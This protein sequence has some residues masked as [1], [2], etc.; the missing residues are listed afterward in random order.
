ML[1]PWDLRYGTEFDLLDPKVMDALIQLIRDGRIGWLWLAPPCTSHS[2]AQNG[3][4]GGQ[5]RSPAF[6]EGVPPVHPLAEWGNDLWN[7]SID[8]FQEALDASVFAAIEHP[9]TSYAW[10]CK[11]SQ[12]ALERE[13]VARL[14][15]DMCMFPD[16][17][18]QR[19]LKP[20]A[21]MTNMPWL[22]ML[23][24][25]CSRDHEHGP[26]LCGKAAKRAAAYPDAF[27]QAVAH[28][29][30]RWCTL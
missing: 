20:T 18:K 22:S 17:E 3:R 7:R 2:V 19:T 28:C 23:N 14:R 5:L 9:W 24:R 25:R 30:A 8:L 10:A 11:K 12:P 27:A 6:P 1:D 16:A 21:I 13:S 15:V 29:Y 26:R 4:I